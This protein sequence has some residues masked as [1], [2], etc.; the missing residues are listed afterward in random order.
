MGEDCNESVDEGVTDINIPRMFTSKTN[1]KLLKKLNG[2]KAQKNK[3]D[4]STLSTDEDEDNESNGLLKLIKKF[5]SHTNK[6]RSKIS[7]EKIIVCDERRTTLLI[8]NI[9]TKYSPQELLNEL[10]NNS[11][12]NGKFNFLYLPV[13]KKT[14]KNF[15]FAIINFINP[16]HILFFLEIFQ[17]K[18]LKKYITE[19]NLK[20]SFIDINL[21]YLN[22]FCPNTNDNTTMLIPLKYLT[23]FKK[24]HKNAVCIIKDVNIYNEGMFLVKNFK[25]ITKNTLL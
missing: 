13:N 3:N 6:V 21:E 18:K 25:N 23:F 4:T 1:G 2:S 12:I 8:K 17:G 11:D 16:L 14:N 24:V 5:I 7:T 10:A 19:D 9:P 22:K 15:G 20:I